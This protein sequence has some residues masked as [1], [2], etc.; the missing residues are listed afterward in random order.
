MVL[1]SLNNR[2]QH[3]VH[4]YRL[5]KVILHLPL[6]MTPFQ[7]V[8]HLH[9]CAATSHDGISSFQSAPALCVPRCSRGVHTG[10]QFTLKAATLLSVCV[11]HLHGA[12]A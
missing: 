5:L 6:C 3:N 11:C 4:L 12:A 1:H 8:F 7:I 2:E 10:M 9:N